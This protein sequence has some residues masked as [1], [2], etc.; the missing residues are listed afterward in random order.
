MQLYDK[1]N[2]LQYLTV[3]VQAQARDFSFCVFARTNPIRRFAI[4][5][6]ENPWFNRLILCIILA[7][8]VFLAI[9]N[10]VCDTNV[11]IMQNPACQNN[12]R[13]QRVSSRALG[14]AAETCS[15]SQQAHWA[16]RVSGAILHGL[17]WCCICYVLRRHGCF[18]RHI[19]FCMT[20]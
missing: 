7:S 6:V 1:V 9:A 10:P 15:A 12:P 16:S 2:P 14:P 19:C 3:A 18:W 17:P 13:W 4:R 20:V 5:T 11:E 8:C